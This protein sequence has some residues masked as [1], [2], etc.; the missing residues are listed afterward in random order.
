MERKSQ[1]GFTEPAY[2]FRGFQTLPEDKNNPDPDKFYGFVFQDSDF[3]KWVEAA[4][5]SL[6]TVV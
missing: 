6:L 3:Y 5:Y 4:A 2:T 1:P